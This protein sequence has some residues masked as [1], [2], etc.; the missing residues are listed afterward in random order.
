[1]KEKILIISQNRKTIV[2]AYFAFNL[3][4]VRIGTSLT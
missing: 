3:F 4:E 1:M 2:G